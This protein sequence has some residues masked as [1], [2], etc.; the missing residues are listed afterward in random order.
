MEKFSVP[1]SSVRGSAGSGDAGSSHLGK[2][3]SRTVWSSRGGAMGVLLLVWLQ[4]AER[5]GG[6]RVSLSWG[7]IQIKE[8]LPVSNTSPFSSRL[9]G[10]RQTMAIV[11]HGSASPK[12]VYDSPLYPQLQALSGSP[13]LLQG[14]GE[15]SGAGRGGVGAPRW[16]SWAGEDVATLAFLE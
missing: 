16:A 3:G 15:S 1:H 4:P 7:G 11:P 8:E 12:L 9:P 6:C 2:Q 13:E 14:S 5:T 10:E